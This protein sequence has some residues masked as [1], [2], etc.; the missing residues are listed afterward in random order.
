[1][2]HAAVFMLPPPTLAHHA[3]GSQDIASCDLR[4]QERPHALLELAQGAP[5]R[6]G[7]RGWA[8]AF[9]AIQGRA[10]RVEGVEA[11]ARR[12]AVHAVALDEA[13]Q[14]HLPRP[15]TCFT[16]KL[17]VAGAGSAD[18]RTGAVSKQDCW[19][20]RLLEGQG[21][22]CAQQCN[23]CLRQTTELTTVAA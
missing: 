21:S 1:M 19:G 5:C 12:P 10:R 14:H 6:G 22:C 20:L 9:T 13:H 18:A 16:L 8:F 4:A 15:L 11:L 17:L 7:A 2:R 3:A 23:P